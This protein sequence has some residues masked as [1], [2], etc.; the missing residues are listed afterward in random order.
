M[1][2]ATERQEAANLKPP[3]MY[4][5]PRSRSE[6][7]WPPGCRHLITITGISGLR[8]KLHRERRRLKLSDPLPP[9]GHAHTIPHSRQNF[10]HATHP[11]RPHR[12]PPNPCPM[13]T[14][15]PDG[16]A[17]TGPGASA[18]VL[19]GRQDG[20]LDCCSSLSCLGVTH[21]GCVK[22]RPWTAHLYSTAHTVFPWARD[23]GKRS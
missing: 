3:P 7:S 19:R 15:V 21:A 14:L 8:R 12:I 23:R 16:S 1:T 2:T 11:N 5:T 18:V 4:P 17:R 20:R 22:P 10:L 6:P 13:T 9:V